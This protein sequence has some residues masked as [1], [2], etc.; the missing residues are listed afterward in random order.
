MTGSA[1]QLSVG[2]SVASS[3]PS[4]AEGD[5][6]DSAAPGPPDRAQGSAAFEV[7]DLELKRP[8][9]M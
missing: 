1:P 9:A 3:A 8:M 2:A 7:K 4:L 5:P 6:Q